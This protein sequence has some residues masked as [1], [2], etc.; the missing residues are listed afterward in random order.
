MYAV[1][2]HVAVKVRGCVTVT[3]EVTV[4]VDDAVTHF[5]KV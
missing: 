4:A 2:D 3:G 5:R 1:R